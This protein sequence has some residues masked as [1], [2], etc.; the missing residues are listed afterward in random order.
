[1]TEDFRGH[2]YS[3]YAIDDEGNVGFFTTAGE[4]PVPSWIRPD[5]ADGVLDELRLIPKHTRSVLLPRDGALH[6]P[7]F[8]PNP[9]NDW[10]EWASRGFY[11]YDW[12][13]VH[14][15]AAERIHRYE[16]I[17]APAIPINASAMPAVLARQPRLAGVR[18]PAMHQL[19][20]SRFCS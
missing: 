17:S 1:M 20:L 2:D 18:F 6:L 9:Y 8:E 14:R 19:D 15:N 4:G 3:W 7:S 16:L 12:N 5:W 11:A 10:N 13:D